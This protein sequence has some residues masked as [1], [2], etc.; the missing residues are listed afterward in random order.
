MC[1]WRER[2]GD[3]LPSINY[4][5]QEKGFDNSWVDGKAKEKST[6]MDDVQ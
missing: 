5:G 2:W 4:Q 3:K 1:G 6:Q